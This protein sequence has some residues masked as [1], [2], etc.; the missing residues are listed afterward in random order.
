M[1]HQFLVVAGRS[2]GLML[3]QIRDDLLYR[4][5]GCKPFFRELLRQTD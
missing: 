1:R 3:F 2:L 5:D 4:D